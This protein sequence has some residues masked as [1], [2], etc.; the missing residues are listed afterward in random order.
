MQAKSRT[1][2]L[3]N[4]CNENLLFSS[5][6][7]KPLVL[8]VLGTLAVCSSAKMSFAQ[9]SPLERPLA[10]S[11][12]ETPTPEPTEQSQIVPTATPTE[13]PTPPNT[14]P[15]PEPMPAFELPPSAVLAPAS[16]PV[17]ATPANLT[18]TVQ[19]NGVVLRWS[20]P[21]PRNENGFK[22]ERG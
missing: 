10:P 4:L 22:I 16:S 1:L 13:L 5:C 3:P 19:G 20:V 9:P 17:P 11:P 6:F 18:A 15:T 8:L 14:P 7:V 21:S 2:S 12:N